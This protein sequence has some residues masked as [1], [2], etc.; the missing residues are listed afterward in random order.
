MRYVEEGGQGGYSK[1]AYPLD[2]LSF[3]TTM[4]VADIHAEIDEVNF[5]SPYSGSRT[6]SERIMVVMRA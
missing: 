1:C 5:G 6:T 2:S 4:S 3:A